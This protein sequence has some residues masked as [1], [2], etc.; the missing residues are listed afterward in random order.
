MHK[1]MLKTTFKTPSM[2]K[3]NNAVSVGFVLELYLAC[4]Q[5]ETNKESFHVLI[6][7]KKKHPNLPYFLLHQVL[8]VWKEALTRR[9]K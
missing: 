2:S 9:R 7:K 4:L 3:Y 5:K 1:K 6:Y 8:T